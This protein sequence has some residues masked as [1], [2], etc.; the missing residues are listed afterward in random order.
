MEQVQAYWDA[1]IAMTM[2]YAPKVLLAIVVLIIGLRVIK[3]ITRTMDRAMERTQADLSLRRFLISFIGALLKIMLI[4]SVASMIGIATTSFVAIMGAAGLAVGLALQGSLANLAGGVLVLFFKP[5]KVGDFIET[6]GYLGSVH[7]I[8]IFNTVLK[9]PDNKTVILPNGAIAGGSLTNFSTES[10]RRVDM[11]FG[12]GYGD[13][14]AKAK[15]V[16]KSLIDKDD[17]IL[18]DPESMVVVSGLGDSSVNLTMRVWVNSSDY[19][20]VFFDMQEN[21][22][23]TFDKESISIPFPQRDVHLF[24]TN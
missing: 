5:F 18:K 9:T 14:I 3:V 7:S 17:R 10:Q 4:I 15:Q 8:Q 6:Q 20:G 11:V 22:K 13:D 23:L 16:L 24:Q 21:V 19:W 2:M 1:A 12:I